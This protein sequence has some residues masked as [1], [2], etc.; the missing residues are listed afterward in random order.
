[1]T[2]RIFF[3]LLLCTLSAKLV[4]MDYGNNNT[5]EMVQKAIVSGNVAEFDKKLHSIDD[6]DDNAVLAYIEAGRVAAKCILKNKILIATK[7]DTDPYKVMEQMREEIKLFAG[8]I[9]MKKTFE[10]YQ[11]FA[12][13]PDVEE[14][15]NEKNKISPLNL[16]NI[17]K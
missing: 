16:D 6:S 9:L 8:F 5:L 12:K 13:F 11:L 2:I 1:M 7:D 15:V 10:E 3:F 14:V 17:D 4:A